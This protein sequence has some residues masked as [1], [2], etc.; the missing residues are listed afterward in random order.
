MA[1]IPP[2]PR[3]ELAQFEEGFQAAEQFMGFVPNS[4]FTMARVPGL[5]E[6]SARSFA[7]SS[8]TT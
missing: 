1:R 4:L 7:R 2:L 3:E 5:Y 6:S 8:S